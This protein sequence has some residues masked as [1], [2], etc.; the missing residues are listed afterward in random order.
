MP[1]PCSLAPIVAKTRFPLGNGFKYT[2]NIYCCKAA[3]SA[4]YVRMS[5]MYRAYDYVISGAILAQATLARFV[6]A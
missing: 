3:E 1:T 6:R 2:S 4:I 5:D